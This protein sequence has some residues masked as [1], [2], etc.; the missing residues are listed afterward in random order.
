MSDDYP[1]CPKCGDYDVEW[2]RCWKCAGDGEFDLHEEDAINFAP[3]EEFEACDECRGK[4]GYLICH[5]CIR[6]AAAAPSPQEK[7]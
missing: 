4:G 5:A 7:P 6:A 1:R 2:E 3:G